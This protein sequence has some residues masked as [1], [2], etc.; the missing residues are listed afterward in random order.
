MDSKKNKIDFSVSVDASSLAVSAYAMATSSFTRSG[1]DKQIAEQIE[2]LFEMKNKL[3]CKGQLES[4]QQLHIPEAIV[5]HVKRVTGDCIAIYQLASISSPV[6]HPVSKAIMLV[7]SFYEPE[8]VQ[9]PLDFVV[10]KVSVNY[11]PATGIITMDFEGVNNNT[12][13]K[14]T[15]EYNC[16]ENPELVVDCRVDV[17]LITE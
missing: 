4:L 14:A 6:V 3:Y 2:L 8:Y 11:S 13:I 5:E 15:K 7:V 17:S 12:S 1:L 9:V 16:R 10:E